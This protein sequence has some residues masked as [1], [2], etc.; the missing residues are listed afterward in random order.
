MLLEVLTPSQELSQRSLRL[1]GE[2][3]AK[4]TLRLSKI[5]EQILAT[6]QV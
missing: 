3:L 4:A 6:S 1:S 2:A 5:G